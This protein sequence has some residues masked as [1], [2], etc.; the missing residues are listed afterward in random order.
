M[1]ILNPYLTGG[2]NFSSIAGDVESMFVSERS[3]DFLRFANSDFVGD[4][5]RLTEQIKNLIFIQKG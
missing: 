5:L 3:F 1:K 4:G 2:N